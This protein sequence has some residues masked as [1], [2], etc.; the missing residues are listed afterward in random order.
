MMKN[1]SHPTPHTCTLKYTIQEELA[2]YGEI[3]RKFSEPCCSKDVMPPEMFP[4]DCETPGV[5]LFSEGER[6]TLIPQVNPCLSSPCEWG[7]EEP[8]D[9]DPSYCWWVKACLRDL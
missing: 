4:W 8:R 2:V 9:R 5:T 6:G 1:T 7:C 3:Y